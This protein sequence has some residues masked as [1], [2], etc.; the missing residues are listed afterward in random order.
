LTQAPRRDLSVPLP[1]AVQRADGSVRPEY[2]VNVSETGLC[3]HMQTAVCVGEELAVSFRLP[4][5]EIVIPTRCKVVW[6]SH[7]G[8][9][10]PIPRYFETGLMLVEISG[11]HR[12]RITAFVQAQVDRV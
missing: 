1:V 2:L 7:A 5:D 6:T 10:Y 8:E 12:Q 11:E 3:L 9:N 4:W